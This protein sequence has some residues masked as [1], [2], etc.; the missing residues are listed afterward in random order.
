MPTLTYKNTNQPDTNRCMH[1]IATLAFVHPCPE[2]I[3]YA[4]ILMK[5]G[6][7]VAL[8]PE[9]NMKWCHGV[10]EDPG[11]PADVR[12]SLVFRHCTKYWIR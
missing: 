8:S 11:A 4:T 10:P 2:M 5:S 1:C 3:I 9:M 6:D 7:L 12:V